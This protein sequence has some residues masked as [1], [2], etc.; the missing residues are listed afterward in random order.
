[1]SSLTPWRESA[2]L[3]PYPINGAG[4]CASPVLRDKFLNALDASDDSLL[5]DLA[6]HLQSCTNTLPS[7]TCVLL[8]LPQ[9]STYGVGALAV[10]KRQ[11]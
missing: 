4:S 1:M 3:P 9:G 7:A 8:G 2:Q 11:S 6:R 5:R 10:I